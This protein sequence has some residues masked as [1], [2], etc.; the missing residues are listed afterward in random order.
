MP[1]VLSKYRGGSA[2]IGSAML[3]SDSLNLITLSDSSEWLRAG[4]FVDPAPYPRAAQLP[5][6]Q[7]FAASPVTGVGS[8]GMMA[9]DGAGRLVHATPSGSS[10]GVSSDHGATWTTVSTG[11]PF[12]LNFVAFLNGKFWVAGCDATDIRV[13]ES[14]TGA[15]GT[16]TVRT[17][18]A[19][20][21]LTAGTAV[22]E[23]TGTNYVVTARATAAT[24]NAFT[25]PTGVSWTARNLSEILG[26]TPYLLA[27]ATNGRVLCFG[28]GGPSV[29]TYSTDHGV[30]WTDLSLSA[31]GVTTNAQGFTLGERFFIYDAANSVLW[32]TLDP[33]GTWTQFPMPNAHTASGSTLN[34]GQLASFRTADRSAL[35]AGPRTTA[36]PGNTPGML[37]RV[38][39]DAS[40]TTRFTNARPGANL[41]GFC[42]V[43]P[44]AIIL[45]TATTSWARVPVGW[46]SPNALAG[47]PVPL[48]SA[49]SFPA[50]LY[51]RI[52]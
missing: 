52:K 37:L 23:W 3:M 11:L 8:T 44:S 28:A 43:T 47:S 16:W 27:A 15:A 22:I 32:S 14:V 21:G 49:S 42:G 13:A 5:Q 34:L 39:S 41:S 36:S 25:S 48:Y 35:F 17:V 12:N 1:G 10:V 50:N 45:Q 33:A 31:L 30:T 2:P 19:V 9:G 24:A 20:T 46:D 18:G 6:L 7:A 26:N 29:A 4:A 38:G 51:T 40:I